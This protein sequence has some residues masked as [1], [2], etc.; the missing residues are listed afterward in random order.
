MDEE[1]R[2]VTGATVISGEK[3]D[4]KKLISLIKNNQ[5]TGLEVEAVI[6]DG[7][8]AEDNNLTFCKENEIKKY[9]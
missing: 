9:K 2:L 5:N 4:G 7:A 6:G 1:I 3:H 8:Y